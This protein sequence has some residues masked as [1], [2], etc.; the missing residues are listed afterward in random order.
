MNTTLTTFMKMAI[1][2]VVIS[3]LLFIVAYKML[4]EESDEYKTHIEENVNEALKNAP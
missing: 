2:V 4:D 1:T 3:A